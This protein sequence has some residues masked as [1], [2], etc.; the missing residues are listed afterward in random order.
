MKWYSNPL[1]SAPC[2]LVQSGLYLRAVGI[3]TV[4]VGEAWYLPLLMVADRSVSFL[5]LVF[6]SLFLVL[7]FSYHLV[8]FSDGI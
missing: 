7:L 4:W 1:V 6:A 5:R 3:E 2:I 8:D